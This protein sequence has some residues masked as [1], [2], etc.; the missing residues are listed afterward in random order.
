ME[1]LTS[2][3]IANK[4]NI[5]TRRVTTL[6]KDGRIEGAVQKGGV[7]LIPDNIQK[8]ASMKRGRKTDRGE[9]NGRKY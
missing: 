5:S 9:D 6:C 2:N 4:W 8:P 7:W 3:E 1:F